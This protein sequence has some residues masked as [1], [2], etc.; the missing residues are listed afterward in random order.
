MG[1]RIGRRMVLF[2]S[3][4]AVLWG[5]TVP[6]GLCSEDAPNAPVG[7]TLVRSV[8]CEGISSFAPFNPA[9][10]FSITLGRISCFTEFD[11][12]LEETFIYHKW[13]FRDR[14]TTRKKLTLKPPRWATFSSVQLRQ[15]DKGP[16]RVEIVDSRERLV[17]V[18]RFSITD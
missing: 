11:P 14:L 12:V 7:T 1:I 18:L 3:F 15:E 4:L 10:V 13:Y 16:W 17:D 2:L 9:V 5:Q 6:G 8:I